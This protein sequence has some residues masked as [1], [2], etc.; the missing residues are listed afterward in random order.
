MFKVMTTL[1]LNN[2][3]RFD[4]GKLE[5]MGIRDSFTPLSTYVEMLK[6]LSKTKQENLVYYSSKRAGYEWFKKMATAFP[7]LKQREAIT[8]GIDLVSASGWGTPSIAKLDL[9]KN[10]AEFD[11]TKSVTAELYGK[12]DAPVDHL[13]RGLVAGGLS[14]IL[15]KDLESIETSCA[16]RGNTACHFIVAENKVLLNSY[17]EVVKKQIG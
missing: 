6:V 13:F 17:S 4:K 16:A 5:L 14:Y 10:F 8:W 12:S 7:G 1:L 3:M 2:Q 11:L 9:E 15:K